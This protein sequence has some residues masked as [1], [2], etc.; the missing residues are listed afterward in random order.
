MMMGI[1]GLTLFICFAKVKPSIIGITTSVMQR[2][3]SA[4][5]SVFQAS[6]PFMHKV[7]E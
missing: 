1:I 3:K 7:V 6:S 5:L 2:S 4:V